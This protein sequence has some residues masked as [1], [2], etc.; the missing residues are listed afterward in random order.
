M[1]LT[2]LTAMIGLAADRR[3]HFTAKSAKRFCQFLAPLGETWPR[4]RY[5]YGDRTVERVEDRDANGSNAGLMLAEIEG[6]MLSS[7]R[8]N[9]PQKLGTVH[10]RVTWMCGEA[11]LEE[12]LGILAGIACHHR[13]S[14]G[15]AM[16]REALTDGR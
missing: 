10:Q 13:F 8:I 9:L 5:R 6:E 11:F 12:T 15:R 14:I 1:Y 3:L 16:Q 2:P 4:Y 7:R